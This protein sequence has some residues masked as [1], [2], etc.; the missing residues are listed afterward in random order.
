MKLSIKTPAKV[1]LFLQ[2]TGKR[3]D[4]YHDIFTVMQMV[5]LWDELIIEHSDTIEVIC[6]NNDALSG[7]EN[8]IYK[9]AMK[10]Q[11]HSGAKAGAKITLNKII[12]V[13]AGL[14]GGSSDAA[15]A[16]Y[17]LNKLWGTGFSNERLST[18]GGELGSD[19]PFFLNWPTAIGCGR[20]DELIPL[21]YAEEL[22]F[23]LVNPGIH[24][25]SAWAYNQFAH[26]QST[27]NSPPNPPLGK[28]GGFSS[29]AVS[30]SPMT[31]SP[32]ILSNSIS[33]NF[34]IGPFSGARFELTNGG[35]RIKIPLPKG[36]KKDGDKLWLSPFNDFEEVMTKKHPVI[37]NIKEKMVAGGAMCS[38]MS[39]SGSTVF[40]IF[41]DKSS[42]ERVFMLLQ[43]NGWNSWVVKSL[44]R[45]PYS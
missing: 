20:G 27:E 5:E 4:G 30:A 39:G 7:K 43:D 15:A 23:L 9:A 18:I 40:G 33:D 13:G 28:G 29:S 45:P 42:A 38:L 2:I 10:L 35:E 36:I 22:W 3:D 26:Y 21:S 16:L 11:E 37:E 12:P 44:H 1:N 8:L 41:R 19:V 17:G 31:G 32:E 25:S 34:W 6:L 14:G 24:I